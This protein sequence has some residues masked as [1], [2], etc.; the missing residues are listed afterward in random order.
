MLPVN[1]EVLVDLKNI[2]SCEWVLKY[3]QSQYVK[4]LLNL[5]E[6]LVIC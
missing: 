4:K 6:A 3:K 2:D 5:K 1:S